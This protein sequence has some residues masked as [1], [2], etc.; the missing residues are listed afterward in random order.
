MKNGYPK[1][2]ILFKGKKEY[3]FSISYSS[4]FKNLFLISQTDDD[5]GV[6]K[7]L[8]MRYLH[9]KQYFAEIFVDHPELKVEKIIIELMHGKRKPLYIRNRGIVWGEKLKDDSPHQHKPPETYLS[10][11]SLTDMSKKECA[12]CTL[13]NNRQ[14]KICIACGSSDFVLNV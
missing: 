1:L 7:E 9:C 14:D 3:S 8:N 12:V 4:E 13:L 6:D 2:L 11:K 5:L 10:L